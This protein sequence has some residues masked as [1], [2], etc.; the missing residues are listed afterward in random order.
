MNFFAAIQQVPLPRREELKNRLL[1]RTGMEPFRRRRAGALSG[2]MKQKLALSTILLSSPELIILDEPTTGVD[3]LSRIEFFA[4]I[5]SS[6]E[7]R[8]DHRHVHALPGRG[9]KRRSHRVHQERPGHAPGL[10]GRAA[11][12]LPG[13]PVPHPAARERV[14]GHAAH[15]R[16]SRPGRPGAHARQIHPLHADRSREPGPSA[17]RTWRWSR[18]SPPWKTCTFTTRGGNEPRGPGHRRQ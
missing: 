2:G 4:I 6:E 1:A 10:A 16:R 12:L 18:K 14:R 7:R 13:A 17:S 11:A 5:E 15:R 9:R 3:P 8:Q